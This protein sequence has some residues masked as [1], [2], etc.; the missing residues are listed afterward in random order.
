MSF[1]PEGKGWIPKY[2]ELAS[3]GEVNLDYTRYRFDPEKN[4]YLNVQNTGIT[5]GYPTNFIFFPEDVGRWSTSDSYKLLLF[6]GFILSNLIHGDDFEIL[7]NE[8]IDFYERLNHKNESKFSLFGKKDPYEKLDVLLSKRVHVKIQSDNFWM[9]YLSNSFIYTDLMLYH[10]LKSGRSFHS[11]ENRLLEVQKVALHVIIAAITSNGV[12]GEKEQAVFDMFL[13]SSNLQDDDKNEIDSLLKSGLRFEQ[14]IFPE[15]MSWIVKRWLLEL[16]IIV[17]L[18]D[19]II[20]PKE[21]VFMEKLAEK[22]GFSKL[23]LMD[24]QNSIQAFI[25]HNFD[26]LPYLTDKSEFAKI[27]G[28]VSKKMTNLV[29]NNKEKLIKEIQESKELVSLI[30]KSTQRELSKEEKKKVKQQIGDIARS[31]PAL[32]VFM[33]PGGALLLP[34][35]LKILP[36][37]LPS[38]FRNNVL[39]ESDPKDL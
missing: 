39:D 21:Q 26:K 30:S 5:Y 36:N 33:L 2:Y 37:F 34:I 22:L 3:K 24:A 6:E 9:N 35:L 18:A 17:I 29:S 8:L 1:T 15:N 23:D 4:L 32:T 12:I 27:Y 11:L 20:D 38:S 7:P 31:I 14:L 10:A 25:L 13:L 28:G 19:N 16:A